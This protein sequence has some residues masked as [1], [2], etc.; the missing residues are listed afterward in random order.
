MNVP[1]SSIKIR[2]RKQ[3]PNPGKLYI[4]TGSTMKRR[5]NM[6]KRSSLLNVLD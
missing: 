6:L 2:L 3:Y 4:F 5:K 1:N